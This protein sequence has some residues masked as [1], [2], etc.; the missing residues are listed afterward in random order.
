MSKLAS[1][2]ATEETLVKEAINQD[3]HGKHRKPS[4]NSSSLKST[5]LPSKWA[6][7]PLSP[8]E[9]KTKKSSHK[10]N[11]RLPSPPNT[12]EGDEKL[13]KKRAG[14]HEKEAKEPM[15]EFAKSFADRLGVAE[16]P[17]KGYSSH[18]EKH[19]GRARGP[20]RGKGQA[21]HEEPATDGEILHEKGPMT[22]AAKAMALR[23]GVPQ[24]RKSESLQAEDADVDHHGRKDNKKQLKYMTPRQKKDLAARLEK[25]KRELELREENANREVKLKQEV[26]EMFDKMSD[27]TT[28]WADFEDE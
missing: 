18:N 2:W 10:S 21:K 12:A 15:T 3:S 13:P 17:A 23:I 6:D 7:A 1:R 19:E 26:Q 14:R 27:K 24:H 20:R 11:H 4:V 28:S 9:P 5:V 22:D 16:K 8:T 25:E